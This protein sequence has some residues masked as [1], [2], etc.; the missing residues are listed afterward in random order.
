MRQN[1]QFIG[2]D[3]NV[4]PGTLLEMVIFLEGSKSTDLYGLRVSDMDVTDSKAKE[5]PIIVNG[6]KQIRII[7]QLHISS[8]IARLKMNAAQM[9]RRSVSL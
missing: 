5:E 2:A 7:I 4:Q 1:G 6:Y 8:I 9:F 3:L